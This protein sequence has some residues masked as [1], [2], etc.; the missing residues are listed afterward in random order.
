MGSA[1]VRGKPAAEVAQ[2]G[3]EERAGFG[4]GCGGFRQDGWWRV[5]GE[6]VV[7]HHTEL[8]RQDRVRQAW[9]RPAPALLS[10]RAL[11]RQALDERA[12][13]LR[14]RTGATGCRGGPAA[15][16][17]VADLRDQPLYRCFE[18]PCAHPATLPT[19]GAAPGPR[20]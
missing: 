13:R 20:G 5:G 18:L 14:A 3:L 19:N 6:E 11:I 8:V 16:F 12:D 17:P 15:G 10:V 1:A 7:G 2:R 9:D 4:D